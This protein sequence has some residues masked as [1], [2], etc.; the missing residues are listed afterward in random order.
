MSTSWTSGEFTAAFQSADAFF[1][2]AFTGLLPQTVAHPGQLQPANALRGLSFSVAAIAGPAP[3]HGPLETV[4]VTD[5]LAGVR[6]VDFIDRALRTLAA[7]LL[8]LTPDH[9]LEPF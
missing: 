9:E 8:A 5:G 1:Q 7:G 4:L 2:P 6:D 3:Q